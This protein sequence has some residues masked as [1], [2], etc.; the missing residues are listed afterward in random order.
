MQITRLS[1]PANFA[2]GVLILGTTGVFT[3]GAGST[4]TCPT[5]F[6]AYTAS[7]AVLA[8]CHVI[9]FTQSR[10]VNLPY[11]G[12][13]TVY[14]SNGAT[15]QLTPPVGFNP[16]TAPP[17]E[18]RVYGFPPEPPTSN[19]PARAAWV[20]MSENVHFPTPGPFVRGLSN[21]KFN[22][23]GQNNFAGYTA[24][25]SPGY[26]HYAQDLF[27]EPTQLS[28]S[29]SNP[30]AVFWTGIGNSALAQNGI[31]MGG[32]DGLGEYEPWYETNV[33]YVY[34]ITPTSLYAVPNYEYFIQ[35]SYSSGTY[36]YYFYNYYS[37]VG[38]TRT[39]SGNFG[40][41]TADSILERPTTYLANFGTMYWDQATATSS[42]TPI[43]DFPTTQEVMWRPGTTY[44]MVTTGP[45]NS[46]ESFYLTQDTC[47]P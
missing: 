5:S 24:D 37:G 27:L 21:V 39:A 22:V 47:N 30:T 43:G 3:V 42:Y 46:G 11:G 36:Y 44:P 10:V 31:A 26:F 17:A 35:T 13:E 28:S 33:G 45:L 12:T 40:G 23:N 6:N 1:L 15:A 25:E 20:Q 7:P 29:C 4:A 18:L 14:G 19:P 8:A 38:T 32:V 9:T 16:L 34:P 41:Q 2:L